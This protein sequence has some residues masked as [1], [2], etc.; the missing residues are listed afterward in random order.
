MSYSS[1]SAAATS[2][3]VESGFEAHSTTSAPPAFSVRIE[4]RGLGRHVQARGDAVAG[5]R[6]LALEALADRGQHRHL[7]VGPLDAPHALGRERQVLHV[8]SLRRC[9]QSSLSSAESSRVMRPSSRSCLR[10]SH[11][12]RR[13]ASSAARQP[14]RGPRRAARPHGG[15]ERRRRDRRARRRSG[16]E[17]RASERSWFSSREAVDAV[18]ARRPRGTTRP[19]QPRGSAASAPTSPV[20]GG[21]GRRSAPPRR[22]LTTTMSRFVARPGLAVPRA[23]RRPRAGRRRRA[24]ASRPRGSS[25][26]RSP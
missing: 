26:P 12:T 15:A 17:A 3:C 11:S 9:H 6:L 23:R 25:C 8:V 13:R 4:V 19:A 21:R 24:A 5:Q 18:A 10:C 1:T 7:P 22:N 16:A 20:C 14:G 2:S